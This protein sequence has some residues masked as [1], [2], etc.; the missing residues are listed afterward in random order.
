[1]TRVTPTRQRMAATY[2]LLRSF[3]PFSKWNLPPADLVVFGVTRVPSDRGSQ[4]TTVGK[5]HIW[6]NTH[7]TLARFV[8]TMA[9][10]MC[11]MRES[12][13]GV[14]CA[15]DTYRHGEYFN[16]LAKQV[17]RQLGFNLETF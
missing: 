11:H 3:P 7:T 1:M 16:R 5:H 6:M 17:C 2:E 13:S 15:T 9:H 10:E 8:E 12:V 14:Q 4:R